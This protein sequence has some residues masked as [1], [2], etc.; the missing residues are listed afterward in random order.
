MSCLL[1]PLLVNDVLR[2]SMGMMKMHVA[3]KIILIFLIIS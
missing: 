3:E 2:Y 1:V